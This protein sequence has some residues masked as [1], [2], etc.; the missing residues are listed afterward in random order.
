[1]RISR[2]PAGSFRAGCG[3]HVCNIYAYCRWADDLAD[4]TGDPQ[5]SLALL[6][7]WEKLLRQC[8][9]GQATHPVF[10]ALS[11]NHS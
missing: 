7:W 9:Q 3:S 2:S 1:M 10:I 8:Y 11:G 4:E 5:R 6:D